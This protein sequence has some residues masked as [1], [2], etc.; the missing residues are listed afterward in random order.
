MDEDIH[1][2]CPQ[3]SHLRCWKQCPHPALTAQPS[4]SCSVGAAEPPW[5]VLGAGGR[6]LGP[7]LG[8]RHCGRAEVGRNLFLAGAERSGLGSTAP[9]RSPSGQHHGWCPETKKG[10]K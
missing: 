4:P 9:G 10:D 7:G 8:L 2:F 1:V 6:G 5:P 3:D